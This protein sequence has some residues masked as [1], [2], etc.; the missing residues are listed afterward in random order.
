[1]WIP[2]TGTSETDCLDLFRLLIPKDCFRRFGISPEN[3]QDANAQRRLKV[4]YRDQGR[5]LNVRIVDLEDQMDPIYSIFIE[6]YGEDGVGVMGLNINDPRS[7]R[8]Q[9]DLDEMGRIPADELSR[10]R[11]LPEEISALNAGL[12]PGQVKKGLR[13]FGE[14]L[15][16][17]EAFATALGK[18]YVYG[19]PLAY[20][21]AIT[22]E[23]HGFGYAFRTFQDE[24]EWINKEFRPPHGI[25]YRRLDA[26][27]PF[28]HPGYHRTVRGRSWAIHDGVLGRPWSKPWMVKEVGVHA[29][30][31]TLKRWPR[32]MGAVGGR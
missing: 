13:L 7:P 20:H 25:L 28:R 9:V 16:G 11:N 3:F 1:M 21:N 6:E 4:L 8:F 24:M 30:V 2:E 27:T 19:E 18:K 15:Q 12:A 22:Y 29:G 23:R 31:R 14:A 17:I 10:R 5:I 32:S 26:S